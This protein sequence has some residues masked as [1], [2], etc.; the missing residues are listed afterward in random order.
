MHDLERQSGSHRPHCSPTMYAQSD[1]HARH[2][3][4]HRRAILCF[5]FCWGLASSAFVSATQDTPSESG[6][7]AVGA[8][9]SGQT[10]TLVFFNRPIV[11]LRA[12]VLG[13]GPFERAEGAS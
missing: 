3:W 12:R 5:V 10:A 6:P 13:R 8:E 11:V 2:F 7:T 9:P 4:A 1:K